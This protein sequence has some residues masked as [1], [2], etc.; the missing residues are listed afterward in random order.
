MPF[1]IILF[2][3]ETFQKE[4]IKREKNKRRTTRSPR[5]DLNSRPRLQ[6]QC[7][8]YGGIRGKIVFKF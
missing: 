3:K 8:K 2:S 6:N 4:G 1:F 5:R 7:S